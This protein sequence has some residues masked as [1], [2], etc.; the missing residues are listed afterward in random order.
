MSLTF[1]E[2]SANT[3]VMFCGALQKGDAIGEGWHLEASQL[4]GG[5]DLKTCRHVFVEAF[6]QGNGQRILQVEMLGDIVDGVA[7]IAVVVI[8]VVGVGEIVLWSGVGRIKTIVGAC[9]SS[10]DE[11][12]DRYELAFHEQSGTVSYQRVVGVRCLSQNL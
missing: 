7:T 11:A 2:L 6:E 9:L 10:M 3:D 12:G 8:V 5:K 4:V 1:D